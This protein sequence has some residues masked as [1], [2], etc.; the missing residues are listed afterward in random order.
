MLLIKHKMMLFR[1]VAY[2]QP[3]GWMTVRGALQNGIRAMVSTL[4]LDGP[5]KWSW[6]EFFFEK[7]LLDK[8]TTL[9][10]GVNECGALFPK[11]SFLH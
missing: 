6:T 2:A 5:D 1:K 11:T 8:P 7:K 3:V 9:R 4:S 10:G